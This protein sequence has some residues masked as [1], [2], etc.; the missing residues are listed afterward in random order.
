MKKTLFALAVAL[1]CTTA[2]TQAQNR[3][4]GACNNGPGYSNNGYNNGYANNGNGYTNNGYYGD[5]RDPWN[6]GRQAYDRRQY[7]RNWVVVTRGRR[8]RPAQGHWVYVPHAPQRYYAPPP[9]P[10]RRYP[11]RGGY[12]YGR[13]W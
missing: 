8:N 4:S 11:A 7:N 12:A 5:D 3:N 9:P 6:D 13:R 1:F 2:A 10:P